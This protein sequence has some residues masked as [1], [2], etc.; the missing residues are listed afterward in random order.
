MYP[1]SV[2]D[3]LSHKDIHKKKMSL[4]FPL[5]YSIGIS[6]GEGMADTPY[7]SLYG[8]YRF[9]RRA[10]YGHPHFLTAY[11]QSTGTAHDLRFYGRGYGKIF[12]A[13]ESRE[14]EGY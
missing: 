12:E 9:K 4:L 3:E 5:I 10:P 8:R 11:F 2:Y 6:A 1:D 7:L 13:F 14:S